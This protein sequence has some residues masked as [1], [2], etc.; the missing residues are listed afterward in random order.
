MDRGGRVAH[1]GES[2]LGI[3]PGVVV[4]GQPVGGIQLAIRQAHHLG[5]AGSKAVDPVNQPLGRDQG[6]GIRSQ[7]LYRTSTQSRE[8]DSL[9]LA[10]SYKVSTSYRP[11]DGDINI[12]GFHRSHITMIALRAC[13]PLLIGSGTARIL[14]SIDDRAIWQR[15]M[16]QHQTRQ[17]DVNLR[18]Q[19]DIIASAGYGTARHVFDQARVRLGNRPVTVAAGDRARIVGKD[20]IDKVVTAIRSTDATAS[21]SLVV[22]NRGIL[23]CDRGA[24]VIGSIN[25]TTR[26]LCRIPADRAVDHIHSA[27]IYKDACSVAIGIVIPYRAFFQGQASCDDI[28]GPSVE[29]RGIFDDEVLYR[30]C[31]R[32][33]Q[34]AIIHVGTV[35]GRSTRLRGEGSGPA[36][37]K[38]QVLVDDHHIR[39]GIARK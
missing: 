31:P 5:E 20:R 6:R 35:N 7:H 34:H 37:R 30:H 12:A 24:A 16:Y 15:K 23:N 38:C 27:V 8:I 11:T 33:D 14:T 21:G 25:T 18:V 22:G 28:D 26:A 17:I 36:A 9:A 1:V 4:P 19:V 3:Q 13:R 32:N 2:Q 10:G 39:R 29:R